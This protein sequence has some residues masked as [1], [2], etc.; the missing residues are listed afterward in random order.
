M[1]E[2]W[3]FTLVEYIKVSQVIIARH[4]E[5]INRKR[6]C[7]LM[8]AISRSMKAFRSFDHLRIVFI[9]ATTWTN[10]LI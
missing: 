2:Q 7:H 6:S 10:I 4:N 1:Q 5:R 8:V 9:H 3:S